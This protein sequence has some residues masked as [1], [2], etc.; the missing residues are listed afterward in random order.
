MKNLKIALVAVVMGLTSIFGA[1]TPQVAKAD[2]PTEVV[3]SSAQARFEAQPTGYDSA[4]NKYKYKFSWLIPAKRTYSFTIDGKIYN[5]AVTKNGDAETPFWFSPD[6]TYTIGIY[7][8]AN[9]KGAAVATGTFKAPSVASQPATGNIEDEYELVR[10]YVANSPKLP[11]K[12]LN[13]KVELNKAI[14][15]LS[16]IMETETF[17]EVVPHTDFA[18]KEMLAQTPLFIKEIDGDTTEYDD[19]VKNEK[20]KMLQGARNLYFIYKYKIKNL[21]TGKSENHSVVLIK[22]GD[23]W[24]F[25]YIQSLKMS[26]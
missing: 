26:M 10:E 9:A 21:T 11:T 22:E 3:V 1:F 2:W 4:S 23:E 16:Y 7:P 15:F 14:S 6:V 8:Y 13:S 25:D 24:K 18:S 12:N 5:A 17:A 19:N 20:V